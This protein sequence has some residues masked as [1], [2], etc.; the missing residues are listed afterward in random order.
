MNKTVFFITILCVL[1][2]VN[3]FSY[4]Q[5]KEKNKLTDA[6]Y[7]MKLVQHSSTKSIE[8]ITPSFHKEYSNVWLASVS[9]QDKFIV[10]KKGNKIHSW[11]L[12]SAVFIE[13]TETGAIKIRLSEVIKE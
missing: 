5:T 11:N 9:A 3:S 1:I 13:K 2:G 6:E 10:F 7:V 12:T 4:G 8:I